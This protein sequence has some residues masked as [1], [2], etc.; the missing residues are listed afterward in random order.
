M[1]YRDKIK[2]GIGKVKLSVRADNPFPVIGEKVT[3]DTETRWSQSI[4]FETDN[5]NAPATVERAN[6]TQAER[7]E[8][9]IV[10]DG[11]L[12]Q[13]VTA[14]NSISSAEVKQLIMAMPFHTEPYYGVEVDKEVART[15]EEIEFFITYENGYLLSRLFHVDINVYRENTV[16]DPVGTISYDNTGSSELSRISAGKLT[17]GNRGIY[18]VHVSVTD[19]ETGVTTSKQHNKL[20]TVT[21]RLAARPTQQQTDNGEY[22]E[23][24]ADTMYGVSLRM[25]ETGANDLYCVF[26]LKSGQTN[27]STGYYAALDISK[28]PFGKDAYTI[29]LRGDASRGKYYSRVLLTGST[30]INTGNADGTPQFSYDTPLVFTVDQD[31]PLT[32]WG[33]YYNTVNY[34]GCI[35]NTVW[36]GR[37][38]Y[39]LQKGIKFDR[40]SEELFWS[41]AFMLLNGTS[42]VEL[43]EIE[44]CNTGF[45]AIASKTDPTDKNPWFWYGNFEER[46]FILHH[47]YIHDTTG[48]GFYL[49]YFTGGARKV[50]YTGETVTFKNLA[51]EDVTYIKGGEYMRRAHSMESVRVYRNRF[52]RLGYDGMQLANARHSEVC[53]NTVDFG[54]VRNEQDQM[55]GIS[56]QSMDGRVYNNIVTNHNGPGMQL[57]PMTSLEVFNNIVN[58]D[59]ETDAIQFLF[60]LENPDMNPTGGGSGVIN[61]TTDVNVHNNVLVCSRYTANGRNTVQM[62]N[63]RFT[64]NLMVN[65]GRNFSNMTAETLQAWND[66]MQG[67]AVYSL[68]EFVAKLQELKIADRA[69]SDFRIGNDSPLSKTGA[70]TYF[71]FDYRGYKNWYGGIYPAGAYMGICRNADLSGGSLHILTLTIGGGAAT[72]YDNVVSVELTYSG[73]T[74]PTHYRAGETADLSAA[75]WAEYPGAFSFT[76]SEGY[77]EKTVY[78]QIK[79]AAEESAVISGTVIYAERAG[80][81]RITVSFGNLSDDLQTNDVN[82][83]FAGGIEIVGYLAKGSTRSIRDVNGEVAGSVSPRNA[84]IKHVTPSFA[85]RGITVPAGLTLPVVSSFMQ[86]GLAANVSGDM[87]VDVAVAAGTYDIELFASI[88]YQRECTPDVTYGIVTGY[89]TADENVTPL[90]FT[91]IDRNT[92]EWMSAR[93]TVPAGGFTIKVSRSAY[94][95]Y[96]VMPLNVMV[97]EKVS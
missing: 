38:Y 90:A 14:S 86:M 41:D 36:D 54:G 16:A 22:T 57:G 6:G 59:Q 43:F 95:A 60:E 79:N 1:I 52:E 30:N 97:L 48:E 27:I 9:Q 89:G 78:V 92:E 20:I 18:D 64:D 88:N 12:I 46:N 31:T 93:V 2:A 3:L 34:S 96:T 61:T 19:T 62:R 55:S 42:D 65:N 45:T 15:G 39:N 77:G 40:Y 4:R 71:S 82:N 23:I 44:I 37:G 33:V 28:L 25:Y 72:V 11:D 21:P 29:V 76:L 73:D 24:V 87:L 56:L 66:N 8:I 7:A 74:P 50:T 83:K 13:T 84:D 26:D 94:N 70:G 63:V 32:I 53:Y 5:G 91:S 10:G 47:S 69:G 85:T 35:R 68:R 81:N 80:G 51:G 49:G 67:N 17:F 75:A 58:T